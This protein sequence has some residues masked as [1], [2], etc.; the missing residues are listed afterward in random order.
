MAVGDPSGLIDVDKSHPDDTIRK[1]QQ[2][3]DR[4]HDPWPEDQGFDES[5]L[6]ASG[7]CM[8]KNDP[9]VVK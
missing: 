6:M 5:L 9:K 3:G 8:N 4:S 7:L 1:Q 2:A